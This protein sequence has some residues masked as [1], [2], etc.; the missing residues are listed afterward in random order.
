MESK[1]KILITCLCN[2]FGGL[3]T[4]IPCLA[5]LICW[6]AWKDDADYAVADY[7]RKRLNTSISWAIWYFA[8][9]ASTFLFVGYIAIIVLGVWALVAIIMDLIR[10]SSG[11][12]SYQ[13]PLT[14]EF[15]KA[16]PTVPGNTDQ[17]G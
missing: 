7:A 17:Q 3:F 4:V 10:A 2:A 5:P 14:V 15:I 1:H 11:D 8:A 9:L 16:K 12:G 13:F 6:L